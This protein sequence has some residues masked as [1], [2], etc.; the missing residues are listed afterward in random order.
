MFKEPN[1]HKLVFLKS[2]VEQL[3]A[4]LLATSEGKVLRTKFMKNIEVLSS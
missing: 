3:L 2:F 4:R 1:F